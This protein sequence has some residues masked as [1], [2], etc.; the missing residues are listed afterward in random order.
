LDRIS[1]TRDTPVD[2]QQIGRGEKEIKNGKLSLKNLA[3][4]LAASTCLRE[5][6]G[7]YGIQQY[8][9][10]FNCISVEACLPISSIDNLY[11]ISK[12]LL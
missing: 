8:R 11:L 3:T 6:A 4:P 1:K 2:S 9:K 7:R 12:P 10:I 5:Y